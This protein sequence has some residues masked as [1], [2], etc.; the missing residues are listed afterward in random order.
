MILVLW[1]LQIADVE[2]EMELMM[3]AVRPMRFWQMLQTQ[4]KGIA[5]MSA[6][7]QRS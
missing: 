2:E 7:L 3:G 4:V 1:V 6:G 5:K